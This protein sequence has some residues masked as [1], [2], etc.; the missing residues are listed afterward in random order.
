MFSTER[1]I[2]LTNND[3]SSDNYKLL[4]SVPT[5]PT[6]VDLNPHDSNNSN[7]I[8]QINKPSTFPP[9]PQIVNKN[10]LSESDTNVINTPFNPYPDSI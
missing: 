1:E 4:Q 2:Q 9:T 8:G 5:L 6:Q 10:P 7:N 3:E